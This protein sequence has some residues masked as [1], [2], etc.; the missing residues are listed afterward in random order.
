MKRNSMDK[1]DKDIDLIVQTFLYLLIYLNSSMVQCKSLE[2]ILWQT[3]FII[4]QF[5]QF[6]AIEA[7]AVM[8]EDSVASSHPI[9]VPVDRPEEITAVFDSISYNKV[10]LHP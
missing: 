7:Y 9:I 3:R 4:W 2:I 10:L 1:W 5:S 8:P 6:A